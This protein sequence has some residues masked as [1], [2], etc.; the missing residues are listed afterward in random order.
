MQIIS[1]QGSLHVVVCTNKGEVFAWGD[2][3]E[4]QIGDGTLKAVPRP[5]AIPA[6]QVYNT[7]RF[8]LVI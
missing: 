7:L 5:R 6:L 1:C 2:N 4:G 3:D 8:S